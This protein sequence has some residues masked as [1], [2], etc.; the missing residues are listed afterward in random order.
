MKLPRPSGSLI[1]HYCHASHEMQEDEP[2]DESEDARIGTAAHWV[3]M[4]MLMS[5]ITPNAE[6]KTPEDYIGTISPNDILID[7]EMTDGVMIY[8]Q[9]ILAYCNEHGLLRELKVEV[10]MRLDNIYFGMSG[11]PD[12]WV[13]NI[14]A[15]E[16]VVWDFKFGHGF[17]NVFENPQ[18]LIYLSGAVEQTSVDPITN[19]LTYKLRIVQPRCFSS[20]GV[21]REWEID[22]KQDKPL[23]SYIREIRTSAQRAMFGGAPKTPGEHC[24]HCL[25]RYK[26]EALQKTSMNIIDVVNRNMPVKLSDNDLAFEYKLL[27][28][29]AN[30]LKYR[31][32]A[33]EERVSINLRAGKQ[34]SGYVLEQSHGRK[35]WKKE[36]ETQKI[37]D[38]M[39]F[40]GIDVRKPDNL[41]TPTQVIGKLKKAIKKDNLPID[42]DTIESYSEIPNT[43]FKI[44]EDTEIKARAAFAKYIDPSQEGSN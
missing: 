41:D 36:I 37:I 27:K 5:Y 43:G 9:D 12:C 1:W 13:F 3:G 2:D 19:G 20:E 7:E 6:I 14:R 26:C 34:V 21:I 16:I 18:L 31:I 42:I 11:T 28:R 25:A 17:V 32:G 24:K 40:W 29:A 10:L 39:A 4:D 23:P 15:Q 30:L 38:D 33:L 8:I 22:P 44:V 35:K